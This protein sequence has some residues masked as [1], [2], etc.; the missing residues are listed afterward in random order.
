MHNMNCKTC[1]TSIPTPRYNLGYR[2]CV[3]CSSEHK[4]SSIPVI[5]HKTGN[6]IQII[7][8]PEVAAE[9]LAKS[10]RQGFGTLRGMSTS[11]RRISNVIESQPL[12]I[13]QSQ[14]PQD[15]EIG[16][17]PLP[18]QFDKIGESVMQFVEIR[19]KK[20]AFDLIDSALQEKL[21]W[22]NQANQLRQIVESLCI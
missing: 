5:N 9:F 13:L 2:T 20:S 4:W 8:D 11:Y 22:K 12:K 14:P 17:K 16:R 18:H 21:I 1:Q 7:K 15:Y 10:A 19:D 6:E 3:N